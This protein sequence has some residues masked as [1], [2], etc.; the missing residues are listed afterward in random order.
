VAQHLGHKSLDPAQPQQKKWP[1]P[2]KI[3]QFADLWSYI[4]NSI[5]RYCNRYIPHKP[6]IT[7]NKITIFLLFLVYLKHS[8][9][10]NNFVKNH[11]LNFLFFELDLFP[12]GFRFPFVSSTLLDGVTIRS[13]PIAMFD[14]LFLLSKACFQSP[15]FP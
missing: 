13:R 1:S 6:P 12:S 3:C 4:L 15:S 10:Q 5:C 14:A 7:L 9:F 11:F 8:V 2:S